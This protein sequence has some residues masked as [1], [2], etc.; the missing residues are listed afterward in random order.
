MAS[1]NTDVTDAQSNLT[2]PLSSFTPSFT[3]ASRGEDG[4]SH[5]NGGGGGSSLWQQGSGNP[6]VAA[7]S[8]VQSVRRAAEA[9]A[10]YRRQGFAETY[11][12]SQIMIL[13][14][15]MEDLQPLVSENQFQLILNTTLQTMQITS[16][17]WQQWVTL[18]GS[19][20]ERMPD[21]NLIALAQEE[22]DDREDELADLDEE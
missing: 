8:L 11:W 9:V 15:S 6:N 3:Q 22:A 21:F 16:D 13:V 14:Y 18:Y 1:F 4:D 20:M 2:G 7:L 12:I 10:G 19:P 5:H 17:V